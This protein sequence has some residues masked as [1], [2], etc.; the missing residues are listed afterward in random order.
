MTDKRIRLTKR[1]VEAIEPPPTGERIVW[2]G[3][4]TGFGLRVS[5]KGRR[6]YFI[7]ARTR[8]GRQ[9]KMKIGVHGTIT[10]EKAREIASGELGKIAAGGNPAE[11]KRQ[12]K[13]AEAKQKAIPTVEQLSDR[14]L[15][16]WAEV[17]KRPLSIRDDRGMI[18]K[19]IKPA[20]GGK[21]VSEVEK[22]D[23]AT[24]HRRMKATPFRANRV[25]ALL[26][27]AFSLA[28]TDW[29]NWT[30]CVENPVK[31]IA[32]YDEPSRER[33]LSP[34][35]LSRLAS[36]LAAYP[37]QT[38][39]DAVRL[40]LLTGARRGE[41]LTMTWDQVDQK[42]GTWIKP[43]AH[44]KQKKDHSVPLWLGAL[45][46]LENLQQRRKQ[47]EPHVFPGRSRAERPAV[48]L[49]SC[50]LAVSKA[51]GITGCR[52]HDLRH[53]Y[54]SLLVNSGHSLPLIGALLGH[55]QAKT[56]QRYAHLSDAALR[57]AAGR[58]D[59]ELAA[60]SKKFRGEVI[61]LPAGTGR[62]S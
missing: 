37:N 7:H 44:T 32:R 60:F 28:T 45:A 26:S 57:E 11:E 20:L 54:A 4:L 55:T 52:V 38:T 35:E 25:L 46:I 3:S 16:E 2:D 29:K 21:R 39:A 48:E 42:R 34:D 24:L 59:T 47:G 31:G 22:D 1:A 58:V 61:L 33:Y 8:A 56:T 9:V 17:H 6:T 18:E 10:A 41:V 5:S 23:I 14:Y 36:A 62:G 12:A 49:K 15:T 43:S 40:L 19:I 13:A 51:A 30:R 53:T 50:W 27:K